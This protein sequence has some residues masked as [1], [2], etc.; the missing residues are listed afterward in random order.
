[1]PYPQA[2]S[3]F[4]LP[5]PS[6][7]PSCTYALFV[8]VASFSGSMTRRRVSR[9]P[10]TAASAPRARLVSGSL[11][12]RP[13]LPEPKS[14][15]VTNTRPAEPG[16]TNLAFLPAY[17]YATDIH[18]AQS[19]AKIIPLMEP[20]VNFV[21]PWSKS[22]LQ[23]GFHGPLQDTQ[24]TSNITRQ[25]PAIGNLKRLI[26]L[27]PLSRTFLSPFDRFLQVHTLPSGPR[28]LLQAP[29]SSSA[30]PDMGPS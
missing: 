15:K 25:N 19:T 7:S 1:M 13:S 27:V 22:S 3:S 20:V 14:P 6:P 28:T 9:L 30:A 4:S 2:F 24:T 21:L 16:R 10:S 11:P 17:S 8:I 26:F 23:Q 5:S 29:P 12:L 18:P